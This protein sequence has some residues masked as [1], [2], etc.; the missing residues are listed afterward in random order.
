MGSLKNSSGAISYAVL[1]VVL[2]L[3]MLPQLFVFSHITDDAYISF[4]YASR[5]ASGHGLSFNP[6]ERVE[7][8]S[9][10]L[11]TLLIALGVRLSSFGAPDIARV[12][13]ILFSLFTVICAWRI[14]CRDKTGASAGAGNFAFFCAI[15]LSNPGF[16]VYATAGLEG[17][18]LMCLVTAGV[19][20]SMKK[21]V[22][23]SC[24]AALAFGL[25]GITRPEGLLYGLLWFAFTLSRPERGESLL[26]RESGRLILVLL[27][28][29]IYELLRWFYFGALLPNTF[30]AKPPGVFGG[31]TLA[32]RYLWPWIGS[33]GG[34]VALSALVL[35]R[36]G[37]SGQSKTAF[38]AC[39][40]P[41]IAAM[42]FTTYA[43]GDWMPFGR[44][45][46]PVWPL[47]CIVVTLW[48]HSALE[49]LKG[50]SLLRFP[51]VAKCI[52]AMVLV[53]S[54]ILTWADAV[55]A[56]SDNKELNMLM[57][58]QDQIAVGRWL[59][60]N[61]REGAAVATI[62]LGGISYAAPKLIFWDLNGLT[63][64]EQAAFVSKG[65]PGGPRN[66]PILKRSPQ[67]LAMV[68]YA[69]HQ[70]QQA[71]AEVIEW[72]RDNYSRIRSFPQG[73]YGTF[74]IWVRKGAEDVVISSSDSQS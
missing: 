39:A 54:S 66:D 31:D 69:G 3:A 34:L 9:N 58:G 56:Y 14:F 12:L 72:V 38:R 74:D 10:P 25:A 47:V 20:L 18:L 51:G 21:S 57:R 23:Y 26:R 35:L 7:G 44:F 40:G 43:R 17:P 63:D 19:A 73:N 36:I 6:G 48:L 41:V 5:L 62:R 2:L 22:S 30:A 65:R 61:V 55:I 15:L 59:A 28:W 70:K 71:I 50:Y 60:D 67:V 45:I 27:P 49:N 68:E 33:V 4:R 32:V 46:V 52:V 16:H 42:I 13:G 1:V 64:R 11:W 53:L 24:L 29:L 8:F 37:H